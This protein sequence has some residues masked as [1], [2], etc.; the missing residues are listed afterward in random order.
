VY[1]FRLICG[2]ARSR[3]ECEKFERLFVS[4]GRP[5]GMLMVSTPWAEAPALYMG[6]PDAALAM[7]FPAFTRIAEPPAIGR[8]QVGHDGDLA[9]LRR[10]PAFGLEKAD[11]LRSE[12][13]AAPAARRLH[14]SVTELR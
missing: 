8:P 10:A 11:L 14:S 1:W 3:R 2:A 9:G 7:H 13:E 4:L 6:L 12:A 5:R